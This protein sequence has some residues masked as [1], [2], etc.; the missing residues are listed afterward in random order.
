MQGL[1][2][3]KYV[4]DYLFCLFDKLEAMKIVISSATAGPGELS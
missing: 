4:I 3:I 1:F 2:L